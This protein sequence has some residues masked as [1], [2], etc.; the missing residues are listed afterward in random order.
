MAGLPVGS[1]EALRRL[2][3]VLA[4]LLAAW[5]WGLCLLPAAARAADPTPDGQAPA[6]RAQASAPAVLA[7]GPLH[8]RCDGLPLSA[9]LHGGAVDAPSIPNSSGGTLPGAFVQLAWQQAGEAIALQLPRTNN[10][11]PPSFTDGRWWWSLEDPEH[12]R[13]R[14]RRRRG[15]IQEIACEPM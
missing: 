4:S 6:L 10:A 12:P 8:Y 14:L 2:G 7:A 1:A 13:F 15:D 11:G 3:R 9:I 5:F